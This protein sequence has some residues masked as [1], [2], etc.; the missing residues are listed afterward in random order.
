MLKNR[1]VAFVLGFIIV[2]ALGIFAA[3]AADILLKDAK[4]TSAV[5]KIDKNGKPYIRFIVSENRTIQGVT[6]PADIPVMAFGPLA[7]ER[8]KA[9]K[10][11]DTLSAVV[12]GRIYQGNEYYTVIKW[13]AQQ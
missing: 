9:L 6:Y 7:D 2:F 12:K 8:A 4:I 11:G 3:Q 5:Q 13:L 10:A 1:T